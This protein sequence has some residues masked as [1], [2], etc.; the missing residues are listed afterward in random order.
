MLEKSFNQ[1]IMEKG[2]PKG[3]KSQRVREWKS[4]YKAE[5]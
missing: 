3:G 2:H 4:E 1:N 5:G